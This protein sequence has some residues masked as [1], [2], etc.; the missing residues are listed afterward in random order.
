MVTNEEC[1]LRHTKRGCSF[2]HSQEELQPKHGLN[3]QALTSICQN[4]VKNRCNF[5]DRCH[6]IHPKM[7]THVIQSY[8]DIVRENVEVSMRR[9]FHGLEPKYVNVYGRQTAR[10]PIFEQVAKAT[11][12]SRPNQRKP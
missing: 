2:A 7:D 1:P 3:E 5:G 11:N 6:F 10:L 4:F 12:N 8:E 9:I